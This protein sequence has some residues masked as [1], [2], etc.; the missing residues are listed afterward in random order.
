MGKELGEPGQPL[1]FHKDIEEV[2]HA[3]ALAEEVFEPP[4]ILRFGLGLQAVD[5]KQ[6]PIVIRR[7]GREAD[8]GIPGQVAVELAQSLR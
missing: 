4:Q 5:G 6:P 7:G 2:H 3:I 1:G 8:V